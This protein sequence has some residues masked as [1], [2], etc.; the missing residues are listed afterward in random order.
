M[1]VPPEL[2]L[3]GTL[4]PI[5]SQFPQDEAKAEA[6]WNLSLGYQQRL[7][8]STTITPSLSISNRLI[9]SDTEPL[10]SSFVSGPTRL[11]LSVNLRTDIYGFFPGFGSFEAIRHKISPGFDYSYSP[12]VSPTDLQTQVFGASEVRAQRTLRD[13]PQSDLRGQAE[14]GYHRSGDTHPR[15][16]ASRCS[17]P[18]ACYRGHASARPR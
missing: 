5:T 4:G 16:P 10:A 3:S 17:R 13:Q 18:G 2:P 12:E 6:G 1:G 14:G 7:I 9:R 11:S 8:G 15:G